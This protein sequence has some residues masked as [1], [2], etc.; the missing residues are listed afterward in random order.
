MKNIVLGLLIMLMCSGCASLMDWFKRHDEVVVT[1]S[2]A[3]PVDTGPKRT[4][5]KSL[6]EESMLGESSGS[7]WVG[8]GQASYLF[9]NNNQRLIGDILNVQIEGY[10]KEQIQTKATVISKLLAEILN[11]QRQDIKVKQEELKKQMLPPDPQ[12]TDDGSNPFLR[13]L[14]SV[15]ADEKDPNAAQVDPVVEMKTT[16]KQLKKISEEEEEIKG[17]TSAKDFPIKSVVTR[18]TEIQKDG[19]YRVRGEQPFMIGK[20]D[21]KLLVMGTVRAEDWEE[22]GVSAEILIDPVFDIISE[23]KGGA[24]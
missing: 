4:T 21:Y 3:A 23:S 20:R 18:V 12:K 19:N 11:E 1:S 17:L 2:A 10:P 22:K 15:N 7:L 5:R 8:R 9:T 6:E 24:L 16:E 13:G 14:A